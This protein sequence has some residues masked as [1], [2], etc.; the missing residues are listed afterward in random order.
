MKTTTIE[1]GEGKVITKGQSNQWRLCGKYEDLNGALGNKYE[2]GSFEEGRG[3]TFYFRDKQLKL[4]VGNDH[5]LRRH[6]IRIYYIFWGW[7]V[8]ETI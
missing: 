8:W 2:L 4:R 3:K 1:Y 7:M 5:C 6:I